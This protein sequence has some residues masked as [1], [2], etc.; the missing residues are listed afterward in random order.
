M[1]LM[2][3][4]L[5]SGSIVCETGTGSGS[6]THAIATAIAPKGRLYSYDIEQSR[7]KM[8]EG[9]LKVLT[10]KSS[11]HKVIHFHFIETWP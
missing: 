10:K 6:L 7:V 4:D 5:K 8:V 11:L 1:I 3:L 2:L 9:D